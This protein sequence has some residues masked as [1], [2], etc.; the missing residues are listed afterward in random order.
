MRLSADGKRLARLFN[1]ASGFARLNT[2]YE[3]ELYDMDTLKIIDNTHIQ[4][5]SIADLII[6]PD[7]RF[8]YLAWAARVEG[9]DYNQIVQFAL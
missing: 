4:P 1:P 7:N 9:I 8:I 2:P 5:G 3:L 6:S